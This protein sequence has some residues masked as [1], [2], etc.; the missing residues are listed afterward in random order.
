MAGPP[1]EE[2]HCAMG[3]IVIRTSEDIGP[4]LSGQEF[5]ATD[6]YRDVPVEARAPSLSDAHLRAVGARVVVAGDEA[7]P[8]LLDVRYTA[9]HVVAPH[10]HHE[11]EILFVVEGDLILGARTLHAGDAVLIPA[12]TLYGFTSGPEGLRFLNF[13]PRRSAGILSKEALRVRRAERRGATN[14]DGAGGSRAAHSD[15]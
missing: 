14:S 7:T 4:F 12:L 9:D 2:V 15:P 6:T 10:A 13:R 8:Q 11:D 3:R 1:A 5:I